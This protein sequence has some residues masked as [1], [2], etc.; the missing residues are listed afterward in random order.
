MRCRA[1]RG[2]GDLREN[3]FFLVPLSFSFFFSG[4]NRQIDESRLT[5]LEI[6]AAGYFTKS[7]AARTLLPGR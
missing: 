2:S 1:L 7:G 4:C 3:L 6:E 5:S